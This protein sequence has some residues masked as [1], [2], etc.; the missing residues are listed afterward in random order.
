MNYAAIVVAAMVHF[1]LGALWFSPL[2]FSNAWLSGIGKSM[3]QLQAA[4]AGSPLPYIVA[5]ISNLVL[6]YALS[7]VI[8]RLGARTAAQGAWVGAMLWLGMV[9]TT[10]L[11]EYAFEMRSRQLFAINAGYP[12][13][14]MLLMGAILAAWQK[15]ART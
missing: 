11:T 5:F 1:L 7:W 14:G 8:T 2:L 4:N 9:A 6:A 10:T 15:Q 13:V 12:L 3:E